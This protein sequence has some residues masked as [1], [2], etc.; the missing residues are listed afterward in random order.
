MWESDIAFDAFLA[1]LVVGG[2]FLACQFDR[3]LL[4]AQPLPE[5]GSELEAVEKQEERERQPCRAEVVG[6]RTGYEMEQVDTW[7]FPELES[8]DKR[9]DGDRAIENVPEI[10]RQNLLEPGY[11][12]FRSE[13]RVLQTICQH[14]ERINQQPIRHFDAPS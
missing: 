3:N 8:N 2:H 7:L 6:K 1:H 5:R 14:D 12:C 10:N 13:Q 9:H 11:C 4:H